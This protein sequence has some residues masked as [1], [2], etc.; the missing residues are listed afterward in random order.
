MS[1][2]SSATEPPLIDLQQLVAGI[3]FR[4]RF[5]VILPILGMLAG[6]LLTLAS[7]PKPTAIVRLM[8]SHENG[9]ATDGSRM[10]TDV[11]LVSTRPIA[12][13]ALRRI[14]GRVSPRSLLHSYEAEPVSD[15]I[16]QLTVTGPS[17]TAALTRAEAIAKAF[18]AAH[19]RRISEMVEA[20]TQAL[21]QRMERLRSTNRSTG[22]GATASD[23]S[24]RLNELAGRIGEL[25]MIVPSVR[26]GT[27]IV[28]GPRPVTESVLAIGARNVL[29][30]A[31]LGLGGG[32]GAA[33]L[34]TVLR[35]RPVLRADI[36]AHLGVSV[37]AQLPS[38]GG[39]RKRWKP[40]SRNPTERDRLTA[41]L[42]RL[43]TRHSSDV[44]LLGIG[45]CERVAELGLSVSELLARQER[46]VMVDD[47]PNREA[48]RLVRRTPERI[49]VRDGAELPRT[50]EES[51]TRSI[52]VASVDPG[53]A[54]SDATTLGARALLV[55]RA[56][57]S[58]AEWLHTVARQL[59]ECE[60]TVLGV[61]LV[62]PDPRD[63]S[64]GTLWNG[65]HTALRAGA[66]PQG[67]TASSAQRSAGHPAVNGSTPRQ[68]ME[69]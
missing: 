47:L 21:R 17:E 51:G 27:E 67:A 43:V 35:N 63:R 46:V 44:A 19:T 49:T 68:R 32:L 13:A 62:H 59:A 8:V 50:E 24:G 61:V 55:V 53:V 65:L 42:A 12:V 4:R 52:G 25:A 40:R 18:I 10:A 38:S 15:D 3:R 5:L 9:T 7:P 45:C 69:V 11:A 56:G 60:T 1:R 31:V 22:S 2:G 36:A 37:I 30:G 57:R 39:R 28:D 41:T 33:L 6:V 48:T 26:E 54:F 34:A 14:D 58:S 20:R 29:L 66:D 16:M 64:D 23:E